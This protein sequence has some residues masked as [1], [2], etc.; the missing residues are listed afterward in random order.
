[1]KRRKALYIN[2]DHNSIVFTQKDFKEDW[3]YIPDIFLGLQEL[4]PE[5]TINIV[6]D[7]DQTPALFVLYFKKIQEEAPDTIQVF[8]RDTG[9]KLQSILKEY[10]LTFKNIDEYHLPLPEA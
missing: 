7:L 5:S 9:K 3:N 2:K 10:K 4:S 1:M 6:L 8:H